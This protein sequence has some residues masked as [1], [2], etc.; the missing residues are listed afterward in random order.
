MESIVAGAGP[1][2]L[3]IMIALTTLL[4]WPKWVYYL[5]AGVAILWGVVAMV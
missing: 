3:G 1:I 2:F 5:W 4:Q